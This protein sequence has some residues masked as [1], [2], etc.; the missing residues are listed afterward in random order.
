[1]LNRL[2]KRTYKKAFTK[3]TMNQNLIKTEYAVRGLVPIR[4]GEIQEELNSPNNPYPFSKIV[5]LNI[6]NPQSLNQKPL[7]F[8]RSVM[9]DIMTNSENLQ[10][11]NL[12]KAP[13]PSDFQNKSK[14]EISNLDSKKQAAYY[15]NHIN[16]NSYSVPGGYNFIRK[17]IA[18]FIQKRDSCSADENTIFMSNG[19]SSAIKLCLEVLI[20]NSNDGIMYSIPQYPIYSALVTLYNGKSVYYY[21]NEEDDWNVEIQDIKRN[22]EKAES[23]G[24]NVRAIVLINPG[25]PTGT[26]MSW[27]HMESVLLFAYE[28][29]LVVLAD[30]VYQENVYSERKKFISFKKV[31][32]GMDERVRLNTKLVSFHSL[33]KGI[34]GECGLRG[35]YME[36]INFE[37]DVLN[38]FRKMQK[39]FWANLH[40]QVGM[41][42]MA[43]Y[44][45]GDLKK[46]VQKETL[47]L[48]DEEYQSIFESLKFRAK[49]ANKMMNDMK[50]VTTNEIEGALYAFPRIDLPEKFVEESKKM[51]IVADTRFCLE[52]LENTGICVVPGSG[53]GQKEGTWHFRTTILPLPDSY[54]EET[55]K[56]FKEFNNEFFKKYE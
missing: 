4:A 55:F 50:N 53:F 26:V 2:I 17:N 5:S 21:L 10:N 31:L 20:R 7:S 12:K 14:T 39:G 42:I 48:I 38:S 9:G 56:R 16:L 6:G 11:S 35:G 32:N 46:V 8:L 43:R 22:F 54:F 51:G 36:M 1:M 34:I 30:E 29:N 44:L 49:T 19:A 37:R 47:E 33:S 24:V 3:E 15:L 41:D 40:G 45:S 27:E 25:N 23:E 52:L 18:N 13:S 28:K